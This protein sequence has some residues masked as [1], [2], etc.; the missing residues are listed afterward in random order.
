MC[1]QG[2]AANL[3]AID[4]TS[5]RKTHPTTMKIKHLTSA[6]ALAAAAAASQAGTLT[7]SSWT[8]GNGNSVN[9]VD[10]VPNP[11]RTFNGSAGGFSGALS[12]VTGFGPSIE[13]Y[14]VELSQTFHL[15]TAYADYFL[16]TAVSYFGSTK[17]NALGKLLS[18]ANPLVSGAA[19]GT[20]DDY[21][22]SLQL[23]I[24]N[25]VYDTDDTLAGGAFKDTSGFAAK[26][27]D[28]LQGA[29]NKLGD[30]DLWVLASPNHQDQLIWRDRLPP[31]EVPEPAS[32]ALA[33]AAL[34]GLG[35]SSRR[36][37]SR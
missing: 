3:P 34:G 16:E 1:R 29:K 32:L 7:L 22:T 30:L 37:R 26:A 12:G 28:F 21:S 11:D 25:T 14:C 9:V 33:L 18:Y 5:P 20:Q 13:T 27:T 17:A 2:P 6:I 23:A 10:T 19:A 31:Q 24:W 4:H 36:R 15:G 8:Y 35:V